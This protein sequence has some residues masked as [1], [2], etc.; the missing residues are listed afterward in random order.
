MQHIGRNVFNLVL[1][2]ILAGVILFLI[3]TRLAQ[4]LGPEAAGQYGLLAA[5]LG[6]FSMFVDLGMHQLVVKKVS[7][8]K[9][10]SSRY[11]SGFFSAQFLMGT[12]FM[13]AMALFVWQADYPP[14]VKNA[15][16]V[17]SVGLLLTSL[18]LPFRAI[19]N[20]HQRLGIIAKVNFFNSVIN[21]A[22]M[23]L[24]IVLQQNILFL[25]FINIAVPL[26]DIIV[27]GLVAHFRYAKLRLSFD[28]SFIRQLFVMTFPFTL[29]TVFSI[30]NRID[31]LM[32]PHFRGF[33]ETGFYAVAYKFWDILAFFPA[34]VGI[35]LYPFFAEAL[36]QRRIEQARLGLETYTRY[37]IALAVPLA[38]GAFL[39]ASPL[40]LSF[41][42]EEFLPSAPAVWL[43]VAAAALLIIYSPVNSLIISQK[44]KAASKITGFTLV[45]NVVTNIILI[46]RY[47]FVAAAVTTVASEMIQLMLYTYVIR[48]DLFNFAFFRFFGKPALASVFMAA[49]L[50]NTPFGNIW[51]MV[52]QG[53]L[54]YFAAL[55]LLKFFK[56]EDWELIKNALNYKKDFN[57]EQI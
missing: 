54:S 27:Y 29:L 55:F 31:V 52:L 14:L 13:L 36:S 5:F 38:T 17:T 3:Y 45:F 15:L 39:L 37:M 19:I 21:G 49:L 51:L 9:Q 32:L 57:P 53:I 44:T 16:Y 20:A 40:T 28:S 48:R 1:S 23:V 25:A 56:K 8:N 41:Y 12:V 18:A 4:Y 24:A 46:P 34:V 35:T 47:G 33:E 42:G 50:I 26:F 43:L 6:V 11:L 30:Y 7:E 22:F 10:D 2:R